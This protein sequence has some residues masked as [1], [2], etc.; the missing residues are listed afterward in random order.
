MAKVKKMVEPVKATY[1]AELEAK[2]LPGKKALAE[3]LNYK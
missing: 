2:G 3:L 1:A